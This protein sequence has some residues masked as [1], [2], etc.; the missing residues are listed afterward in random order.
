MKATVIEVESRKLCDFCYNHGA[1]KMH[2][3]WISDDKSLRFVTQDRK[4]RTY[5]YFS[6]VYICNELGPMSWIN[7]ISDT[8]LITVATCKDEEGDECFIL[9][10]NP[11]IGDVVNFEKL[12]FAPYYQN[13]EPN[14]WGRDYDED[15]RDYIR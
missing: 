11:Q 5:E 9:C 1:I 12:G 14:R 15:W 7:L 2:D 6:Y 4:H 8:G 10:D 3:S 13:P